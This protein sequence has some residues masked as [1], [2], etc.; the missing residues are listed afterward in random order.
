MFR[1]V[2]W[3]PMV[4]E[5]R[6]P[7]T[8]EEFKSRESAEIAAMR[9]REEMPNRRFGVVTAEPPARDKLLDDSDYD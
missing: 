4:P 3:W 5:A 6:Q 1:I 8:Q 9:L 7:A 2:K